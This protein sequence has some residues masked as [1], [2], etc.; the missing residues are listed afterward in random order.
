MANQ[1]S[2]RCRS[3]YEFNLPGEFDDGALE[4]A[5]KQA[6]KFDESIGARRQDLTD[7]TV[8]TIDPA[9]A[10]DFDDAISLERIENGHWLLGVHIADV[11]HFVRPRSGSTAK[12]KIARPAS[13]CPTR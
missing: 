1:A 3:F 9:T 4:N 8:I 12:R 13:T 6:E 7:E 5:R 10:R 11:S 2:T